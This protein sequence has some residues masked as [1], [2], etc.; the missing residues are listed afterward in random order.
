VRIHRSYVLNLERLA[1]IEGDADAK[2][3]VLRD[4]A[5]LPVSRSGY[6]RL[7]ALL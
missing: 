4:G 5:R 6:A 1:R 2:V 3:A 7:K